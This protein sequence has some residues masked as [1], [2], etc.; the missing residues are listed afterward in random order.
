MLS[1]DSYEIFVTSDSG[2]QT[3][4][5]EP[6]TVFEL[7]RT[8]PSCCKNEYQETTTV[9]ILD[10]SSSKLFLLLPHLEQAH[11]R[12]VDKSQRHRARLPN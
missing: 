8:V 7:D 3:D 9:L 2:D 12:N 5:N 11:T 10:F 6:K 1:L 4:V